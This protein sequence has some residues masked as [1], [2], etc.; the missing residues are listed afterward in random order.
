MYE[1][2]PAVGGFADRLQ[3]PLLR[4]LHLRLG[5]APAHLTWAAFAVSVAAAGVIATGRVG[6]GGPPLGGRP[7]F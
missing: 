7:G 4:F 3:R 6:A 5:L 1:R 2:I